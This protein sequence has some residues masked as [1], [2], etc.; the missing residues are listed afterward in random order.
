MKH[1]LADLTEDISSR[2]MFARK[3]KY[4]PQKTNYNSTKE[5]YS[6]T[7]PFNKLPTENEIDQETMYYLSLRK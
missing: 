3:I 6:L 7:T 4:L 5:R 2:G 1:D